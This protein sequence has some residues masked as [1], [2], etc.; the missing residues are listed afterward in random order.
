MFD[1]EAYVLKIVENKVSA[2]WTLQKHPNNKKK[3]LVCQIHNGSCDWVGIGELFRAVPGLCA[4]EAL[5]LI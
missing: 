4:G 5:Y 1:N 3:L 2:I